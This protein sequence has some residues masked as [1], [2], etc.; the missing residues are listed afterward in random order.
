MNDRTEE[1]TI[2]AV[3][4]TSSFS[5]VV[6][7]DVPPT[8]P[9]NTAVTCRY[10]LTGGLQPNSRDW[11]GIFKV[12]WNS[13]KMYL[14]YVWVEPCLDHVG[15]EPVSQHV[16]FKE[17]NLL[18][19]DGEFYQFC[20]VDSSGRVKGASTPFCFQNP[21]ETSLDCSLEKDILVVTTQEQAEKMEK[22]KED[23]VKE[24]DSLKEINEILRNEL[25]ERLHEI[26]C[27][28]SCLD[29]LKSKDKLETPLS[30]VQD[31]NATEE[32]LSLLQEKCEKAVRKIN[33]LKGEKAELQQKVELQEAEALKQNTMLKETEQNYYKLQDRVQLLQVDVQSSRKD[34]EKLHAE[35]QE[36]IKEKKTLED[37]K[38]ENKSLHASISERGGE[39]NNKE[40]QIQALL[41]QLTEAR[42]LLHREMQN[43]KEANKRAEGAEQEL[44]TVKKELAEMAVNL[45][46][47]EKTSQIQAQLHTAQDKIYEMAE[48][49]RLDRENL[50]KKNEKLQ[51]EV[52]KLHKALFDYQLASV[53]AMSEQLPNPQS[54]PALANTQ[55]Q[56][57]TSDSH[58]YESIDD[59]TGDPA[60]TESKMRV[61]QHCQESFPRIGEDELAQHEQS[62][63]VCPFCTLI[64][65]DWDQQAFEDHVYSHED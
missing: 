15:L 53:A 36:L 34:N 43:C 65:D 23:F 59:L 5:Q 25:D 13:T 21:A 46:E 56:T 32:S 1:E 57:Y 16:V 41:T 40:V 9:P 49:S 54:P 62:H 64:C 12:G 61:C 50:I 51:A 35:I 55:E 10:T 27:L 2:P 30:D 7:N 58:Y 3:M 37:L 44:K 28:R 39:E 47:G 60:G 26:C 20:Y 42:R 22:E 33:M 8:Y 31:Y 19:D 38:D 18:K 4:E 14:C 6:F 29:D 48:T 24:I 63:K 45:A 52:A 11:I 17:S